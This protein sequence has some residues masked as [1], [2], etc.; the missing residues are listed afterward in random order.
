MPKGF[1]DRKKAKFNAG[2]YRA[3][4]KS[5]K[6]LVKARVKGRLSRKPNWDIDIYSL[7]AA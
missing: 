7:E 5:P 6:W 1:Y 4:V 3:V 2:M